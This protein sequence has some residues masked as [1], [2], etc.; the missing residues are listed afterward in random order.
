MA[1]GGTSY[2]KFQNY[3][4]PQYDLKLIYDAVDS[5]VYVLDFALSLIHA[6][7][8]SFHAFCVFMVAMTQ[9]K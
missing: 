3:T 4:A 1:G 5:S 8:A 6:Q 9:F 2:I 7:F